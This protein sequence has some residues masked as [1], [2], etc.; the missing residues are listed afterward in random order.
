MHPL[1]SLLCSVAFSSIITASAYLTVVSLLSLECVLCTNKHFAYFCF[2]TVCAVP[3]MAIFIGQGEWK[4]G[5]V[6]GGLEVGSLAGA[7]H[8]DHRV[9][10]LQSRPSRAIS[11]QAPCSVSSL[12]LAHD[13]LPPGTRPLHSQPGAC[14]L[15]G[16]PL[17]RRNTAPGCEDPP[18]PALGWADFT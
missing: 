2:T 12:A 4:S 16:L 6:L 7:C 15:L 3:N 8:C 11:V 1:A 9:S 14:S 5:W 13:T 17:L 18:Q 10:G